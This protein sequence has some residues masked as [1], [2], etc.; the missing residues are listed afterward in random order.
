MEA[1]LFLSNC[2]HGNHIAPVAQYRLGTECI[3]DAHG[4]A[5]QF[6]SGGAEVQE[7]LKTR[8]A[9]GFCVWHTEP[10]H[11]GSPNLL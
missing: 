11:E 10:Y 4:Q 8:I 9:I 3:V 7:V 2:P 6:V 1:A 5:N